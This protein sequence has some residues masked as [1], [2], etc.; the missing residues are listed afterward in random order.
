MHAS[1]A[2]KQIMSIHRTLADTHFKQN[3]TVCHETTRQCTIFSFDTFDQSRDGVLEPC[4]ATVV[5]LFLPSGCCRVVLLQ[6][7][8]AASS[9][10]RCC[11]HASGNQLIHCIAYHIRYI[12]YTYV[13]Y[14][15]EQNSNSSKSRWAKGTNN[16]DDL[17][18][19]R[20][21]SCCQE[22]PQTLVKVKHRQK[23]SNLTPWH[24]FCLLR[25]LSQT[26]PTQ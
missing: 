24:A 23:D 9:Q 11:R 8:Q 1:H 3:E 4:T 13:C 19:S 20:L 25:R 22:L 15:A 7:T 10:G 14:I 26:Q 17:Q 16:T 2:S 6:F 12:L 5:C 18:N 21:L